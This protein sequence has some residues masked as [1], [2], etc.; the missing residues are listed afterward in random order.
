MPL[1]RTI[2][3]ICV[4]AA[5][6]LG[7]WAGIDKL[8]Q[9]SMQDVWKERGTDRE[10]VATHQDY[11]KEMNARGDKAEHEGILVG[12]FLLTAAGVAGGQALAKKHQDKKARRPV[13]SFDR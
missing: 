11:Q 7:I 9:S 2:K 3:E 8:E 12:A 10:W 6:N 1:G 5:V 13:F 4:Y